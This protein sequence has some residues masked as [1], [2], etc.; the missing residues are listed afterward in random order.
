MTTKPFRLV[1]LDLDG[2]LVGE[3]EAS[4]RFST[5]WRALEESRRPLLVYNSGRLI[6]DILD[7]AQREDLPQ[8]DY[9]IGGVGTQLLDCARGRAPE[10]FDPQ[11]RDGWDPH[12]A[13]VIVESL[14]DAERQPAEF[15]HE[16]K[17]S[18]YLHHAEG[19]LLDE[20]RQRLAACGVKANVVYSSHRDLDI[21][22]AAADKG[23]TLHWL[24][25]H[26]AIEPA[27]V[28]VA[29]D[30]GND[31]AMFRLPGVSGIAVGNAHRE[32]L[33][34]ARGPC[35]HRSPWPCAHGLIE[36]LQRFGLFPH[37]A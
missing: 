11:L 7:L 19:A 2:T 10:G 8:P 35:F 15:L 17:S 24:C 18:W 3:A 34:L 29:G 6:D 33:E 21:L 9:V 16:Y 20:L 22:P 36:G 25:G 4:R 12:L 31:C 30:A 13:A 5:L 26:L 27:Q 1:S 28:L 32:L 23:R 14:L 37:D